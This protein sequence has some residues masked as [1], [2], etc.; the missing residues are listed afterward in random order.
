[1]RASLPL[2]LVAFLAVGPGAGADPARFEALHG[3]DPPSSRG[4]EAS[5]W[6]LGGLEFPVGRGRTLALRA[7][8]R[9]E[10]PG[11]PFRGDLLYLEG[12]ADSMMNHG[13]Y[14]DALN[15]AG[16]RVVSFDYPGQGGSPGSMNQLRMQDIV[17]LGGAALARYGRGE[18]PRAVLGWSTGG[19][20]AYMMAHQG[21]ADRVVMLAPGIHVRFV[22]GKLG[23]ATLET[24]TSRRFPPGEDPHVDPIRQ[25]LPALVPGFAQ[26][27]VRT[28]Y[29]SHR[30]TLPAGVR[31]LAFL[32]GPG[33]RYVRGAA[34]AQV[35]AAKAPGVTRVE[36]PESWHEPDNEV[37]P[38]RQQVIARTLAFL[39]TP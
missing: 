9:P 34:S 35:L 24:L 16:Y 30:W 33:D 39:S 13:P 36:L 26:S 22:V 8:Y 15:A 28:A 20:A 31:G 11:V 1:M 29:A 3:F 18:G 2:A 7:G 23:K 17:D 14:F 19:L 6:T 21:R 32:T 25:G 4:A 12:F 27:L 10:A 5:R 38:I 37:E